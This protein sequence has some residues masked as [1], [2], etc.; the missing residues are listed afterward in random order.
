VLLDNNSVKVK[1]SPVLPVSGAGRDL[2]ALELLFLAVCDAF[3]ALEA[4]FL[5]LCADW[6]A[7]GLGILLFYVIAELPASRFGYQLLTTG[8]L[9]HRE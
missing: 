7:G 1:E 3:D 4:R 2:G 6:S 5:V 9:D 8:Q